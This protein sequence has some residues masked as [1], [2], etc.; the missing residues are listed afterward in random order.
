MSLDLV[1]IGKALK[2]HREK[3]GI[4]QE[5]LALILGCTTTTIS[6]IENGHTMPIFVD[7]RF[8]KIYKI[9][10]F[11]LHNVSVATATK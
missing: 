6:R 4:T 5:G 7:R 11:D 2:R 8:K 9:S 3:Q 10:I 1:K